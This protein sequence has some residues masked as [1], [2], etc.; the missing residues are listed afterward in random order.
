MLAYALIPNI[1]ARFGFTG[2]TAP[3]NGVLIKF[4]RVVR[5][6]LPGFSV[7]PITAIL[8]GVKKESSGCAGSNPLAVL[9]VAN[10]I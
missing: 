7:A 9:V 5:P 4:Q 6:T 1:L 2:N 10:A 8:L 3:P